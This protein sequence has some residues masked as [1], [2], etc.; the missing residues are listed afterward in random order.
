MLTGCGGEV[1]PV[2]NMG[3][4]VRL[5]ATG[6]GPAEADKSLYVCILGKAMQKKLCLAE[7]PACSL[8]HAIP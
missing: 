6:K 1:L 7:V 3:C 8:Y 2:M 4:K 5:A